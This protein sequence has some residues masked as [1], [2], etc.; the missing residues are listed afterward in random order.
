MLSGRFVINFKENF[1]K[2]FPE[3]KGII[4]KEIP[5]GEEDTRFGEIEKFF[6]DSKPFGRDRFYFNLFE[7]L[8]LYEIH[9]LAFGEPVGGFHPMQCLDCASEHIAKAMINLD[10][11]LKGYDGIKFIG[12]DNP[13]H[14]PLLIGNLAEA[15]A[16]TAKIEEDI[17]QAIR[18]EKIKVKT[19]IIKDLINA[20]DSLC[21]LYWK[22]KNRKR[23][24]DTA[25]GKTAAK[26][27]KGCG[28]KKKEEA[29]SAQNQV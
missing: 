22:I 14:I 17:S 8:S 20:K 2:V 11:V 25:R 9:T 7:I 15:E 10:E 1:L 16:Q 19:L 24:G 13:N 28:C 27:D 12:K 21:K 29:S 18:V 5:E 4:E 23:G 3:L 6:N 26:K